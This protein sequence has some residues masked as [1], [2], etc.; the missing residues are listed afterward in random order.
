[1]NLISTVLTRFQKT[2]NKDIVDTTVHKRDVGEMGPNIVQ[3]IAFTT[4]AC[5]YML[6]MPRTNTR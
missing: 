1:M 2:G 4:A 5:V 6:V 3:P